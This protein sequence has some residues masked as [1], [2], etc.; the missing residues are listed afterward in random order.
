MHMN[1]K[2]LKLDRA[3]VSEIILRNRC[4]AKDLEL[5]EFGTR[6]AGTTGEK[7]ARDFIMAELKSYGFDPKI[8]PFDHLGWRRGTAKLEI[9]EPINRELMTI[10]LAGAPS[11]DPGGV[12]GDV[13]Y[14]GNGTP[15]EFNRLKDD[16]KDRI[17]L[18]TSLSPTG[19]CMPPR[20]CHRR[21]KYGRAV[22]FGAKAF[23]FMN[24][25]AGMVPQTGSTLQNKTGEIP[26]VTVPFEEGEVLKHFLKRGSVKVRL[27][28]ANKTF[29]NQSCNI[30]AE[31]PGKK[32]DEIVIIGGHYD[33]HDIS[34]GAMDNG[35]GVATVLE[36]ARIIIQSG[37]QFEKTIRFVFF[38]V[39]EMA[40]VGSSFYVL[41]HKEELD[42]IHLMINIDGQGVPGGKTF[43]VAGFDD[44]ATYILNFSKEIE[45]PMKL[46]NPSFG[47]DS[48]S[49]TMAGVP[50][51][52]IRKS[53][54]PGM[55]NYKGPINMEDRGWGHTAGDTPD[56]ISPFAM[57]EGAIISGRLL[58]RAADHKG[59]IAKYR[60]KHEVDKI[61]QEYGMDEVFHYMRWP[62]IP[63]APKY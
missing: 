47:G 38:G 3:I 46:K 26:A 53:S 19:E 59:K 37:E 20:Q 55:F 10:S 48:V 60:N 18:S 30:V 16:I 34:P 25:Q 15:A 7:M 6:F 12:T 2:I 42:N 54:D 28:V 61:L 17:V 29:T 58:V 13:L 39:E 24:S 14:L 50:T 45:Y 22:E 40:C 33:S 36:L 44:V 32:K 51:A 9:L 62:T 11:T 8:E 56:K 21:A 4:Y 1:D 27:E 31:L 57:Y 23:I 35:A 63:I 5:C 49:F 43:D 52:S 41:E